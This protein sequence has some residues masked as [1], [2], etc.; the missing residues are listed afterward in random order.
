MQ[1]L[2]DLILRNRWILDNFTMDVNKQCGI[3]STVNIIQ[4]ILRHNKGA[5]GFKRAKQ[6]KKQLQHASFLST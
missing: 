3:Q 1:L 2:T 5:D 4:N 6:S